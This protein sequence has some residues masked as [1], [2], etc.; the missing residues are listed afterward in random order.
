MNDLNIIA[1]IISFNPKLDLL[2][3]EYESI[4]HQVDGIIYIDNNSRNKDDVELWSNKREKV[5]LIKLNNNYGIGVAQN[6]GIKKALACGASHIIIFDQDSVINEGFVESLLRAEEKALGDGIKVGLTGPV[7][8]S[9]DDYAYPVWSVEESKLVRIPQE[10]I[11]DYRMVTHIIASGSLIRRE[12]LLKV[13]LMREDLFLGYI[14]F[15]YC[16]RAAEYGY[17]TI[18]T[19]HACMRHQMGDKQILIHGRKIGLYS[20]FRRY[21]DCRNTILIQR[22]KLFP[23]SLKRYYLK[24]IFGKV[25]ISLF[26]GPKRWKQLQYCLCGFFDGIRGKAGECSI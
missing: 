25:I 19:R 11:R 22:D 10:G 21:F 5:D 17:K 6:A 4:V 26:Y 1:V 13:G 3:K 24:L 7:Y 9:Y 23:K 15:E 16:F 14:D 18:V 12:T 8:R 2:T 20:P